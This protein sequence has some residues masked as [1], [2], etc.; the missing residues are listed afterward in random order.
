MIVSYIVTIYNKAPYIPFVV[1][2]LATQEGAFEREFI[3]VDDGSTDDSAG[4]LY[5]LVKSLPGQ[6]E[7]IRQENRGPA[8]ASNRG[9]EKTTGDF[10]KFVD[11]DDILLPWATEILLDTMNKGGHAYAFSTRPVPISHEDMSLEHLDSVIAR[12]RA[13][14][15]NLVSSVWPNPL[16]H[17]IHRSHGNPTSWIAARDTVARIG[18][19][20]EHIFIQDYIMELSLA[21]QGSA[22][23][24]PGPIFLYPKDDVTRVSANKA[25]IL[26]DLNMA[27]AEMFRRRPEVMEKYGFQAAKRATGRAWHFARRNRVSRSLMIQSFLDFCGVRVGLTA[28]TTK[29]FES[30]AQV[31]HD[32]FSIR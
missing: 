30:T 21:A 10:I 25:Q 14:T 12:F 16:Q 23:I 7:V 32:G 27:L 13:D 29:L 11:G 6:V 1:H 31:F 9:L 26:H 17:V 3:F 24:W 15:R 22:G 4:V 8:V 2:G 20:A 28:A 5:R 19:C 18:G